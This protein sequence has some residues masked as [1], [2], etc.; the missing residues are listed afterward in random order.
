[1]IQQE[2]SVQKAIIVTDQEMKLLVPLE[3]IILTKVCQPAYH[4][5]PAMFAMI[6]H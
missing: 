2:E 5:L 1:M 6:L 3:P 4:V